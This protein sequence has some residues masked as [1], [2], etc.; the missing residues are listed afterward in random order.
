MTRYD[1][2]AA[3]RRSMLGGGLAFATLPATRATAQADIARLVVPFPPGGP[4][5]TIARMFV[6]SQLGDLYGRRLLVDN[7]PGAGGIVGTQFV[8]R[9]P[10]DGNSF[11]LTPTFFLQNAVAHEKPGYDPIK[12]FVAV[13]PI[14]TTYL[15]FVVTAQ[16]SAT[17]LAEFIADARKR[18]DQVSYASAGSGTSTHL[19]GVALNAAAGLNMNHVPYKGEAPA[20]QDFLGGHVT[21]GFFAIS[22]VQPQLDSGRLKVLA[23]ARPQRQP[24]VPDV[25][26]L[27][28]AGIDHPVFRTTGWFGLFAPAGT[29]PAL[30]QRMGLGV[31]QILRKPE[32]DRRLREYGIRPWTEA[33]EDFPALLERDYGVWKDIIRAADVKLSF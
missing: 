18:G 4:A 28:E 33:T 3:T 29:P 20:F 1:K 23:V 7:K 13:A 15:V 14:G 30:V 27:G 21:C 22:T 25:P 24:E 2:G 5:D 6:D 11:L 26:T 19:A 32:L 16:N 17:N 31:A 8:A 10:A 12:D 9:A